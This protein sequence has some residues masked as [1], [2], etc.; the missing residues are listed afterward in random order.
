MCDIGYIIK[1]HVTALMQ[2]LTVE[3]KEYNMQLVTTKCLNTAVMMTYLLLGNKYALDVTRHCDV[4]NVVDRNIGKPIDRSFVIK[5]LRDDLL[6][7]TDVQERALY[8]VMIT[9]GAMCRD[10]NGAAAAVQGLQNT[11][12][13]QNQEKFFHA[14]MIP[15]PQQKLQQQ[16][17][18]QSQLQEQS[19]QQSQQSQQSQAQQSQIKINTTRFSNPA[20]TLQQSLLLK[21]GK[22]TSCKLGTQKCPGFP[23][24]V[25]V[26]EKLPRGTFNIYQ[27]YIYHYDLA[28]YIN[29]AKSLSVS[30]KRMAK[31]LDGLVYILDTPV[32]DRNSTHAWM[33]FTNTPLD[34]SRKWEGCTRA[35]NTMLPC[36]VK[37][38]TGACIS[39][40]TELVNSTLKKLLAV[41]ES[42]RS[43]IY[44]DASMFPAA[45]RE[46]GDAPRPAPLTVAAMI[47]ELRELSDKLL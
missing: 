47:S 43:K 3:L 26:L 30:K 25:F 7:K 19:L 2:M 45:N 1:D 29:A 13:N 24:H 38:R 41:P 21:G 42:Q 27:S 15:P 37:V 44:G 12:N 17:Q 40:L 6:S 18:L 4:P 33:Q 14:R 35:D 32:W 34:H 20:S 46:R 23:G 28:E 22:S 36:V 8:Y 5:S 31:L 11:Q 39:S 16:S 9:D 10:L